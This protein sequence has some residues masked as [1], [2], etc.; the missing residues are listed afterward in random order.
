MGKTAFNPL[1]Q[2]RGR[3]GGQVYKVVNGKQV[4]VPYKPVESK[5]QGSIAQMTTR[6]R[7]ALAGKYSKIVPPEILRGFNG[8][9]VDRRSLFVRNITRKATVSFV[10]GA[11]TAAI[12]P[13]DIIFSEGLVTT[14]NMG[15]P[16]ISAAGELTASV[17][18]VPEGVDAVLAIAVVENADGEYDKIVYQTAPVDGDTHAATIDIQTEVPDGHHVR[19]YYVPLT[20]TEQA[21][22]FL[23]TTDYDLHATDEYTLTMLLT[24]VEGAYNW[25]RS[26]FVTTLTN[27]Q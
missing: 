21:R 24:S 13:E 20:V 18:A 10:D 16:A 23:S 1:S 2:W 7:F 12:A 27:G 3:V 6:A 17:T 5:G 22:S 8:S 9:K 11:V 4:V 15:T 14:L 26:Q 25:G 19:L